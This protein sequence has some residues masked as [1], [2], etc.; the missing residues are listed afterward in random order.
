MSKK[1]VALVTG[2]AQ[3]IGKAIALRLAQ[4]GFD[5]G[6]NDLPGKE[7]SLRVL[8]KEIT[9][10]GRESTIVIADISSEEQVQGMI[11]NTVNTLGSLDVMV[12]NGGLFLPGSLLGI[13]VEDWDRTFSV[14]CRG[15][16]L[17]YRYAAKQMIKQGRGG[18]II[19]ASS[20]VGKQGMAMMGAYSSTKF[21]IRGLTQV[22]AQEFGKHGITVN[23]YAPGVIDTELMRT[24]AA[25]VMPTDPAGMLEMVKSR[26]AVGF[27]GRPEDIA[28]FVAYIVGPESRYVTGQTISINGG[29]YYD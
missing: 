14:N 21:G 6:L 24:S 28:S 22:A 10:I 1:G 11:D 17:C 5:V 18:R 4:D 8:Q 26:T 3:G 12:A 20:D 16:F 15:T 25:G 7:D 27:L 2:S 23:A 19:G 9:S 13:S 29:W